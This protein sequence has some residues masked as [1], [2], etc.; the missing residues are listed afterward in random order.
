MRPDEKCGHDKRFDEP[1]VKCEIVS[2]EYYS[3]WHRE[4]HLKCEAKLAK[5]RQ[6]E[7]P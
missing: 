2:E 1:C 7:T 4:A 3:A 6:S 5:L